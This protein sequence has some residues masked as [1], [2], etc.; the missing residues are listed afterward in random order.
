[1]NLV[2]PSQP[3]PG[4]MLLRLNRPEA[5]N[6]LSTALLAEL[7]GA[8]SNAIDDVR[9]RCIVLTGSDQ[10]FSCGADVKEMAARGIAVL[11]DQT[12]C[13]DWAIVEHCPKPVIAAVNGLALGGG[14]ELAMLADFIIASETARFGQPEINL[15]IIPGDGAT[16]RLTRLVGRGLAA[17]MILSGQPIDAWSALRAGLVTEVVA[18]ELLLG[19]SLDIAELIAGKAALAARFAKQAVHMAD[20]STLSAGLAI[21]RKLLASAFETED[22]K[23]GMAA[24]VQ[25]RPARFTGR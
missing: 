16:Q 15:G 25:K 11:E 3:R 4:V 24:F 19:T 13:D 1:M 12:R 7:A 14:C 8:F 18:P 5:R 9:M 17:R 21:E 2:L 20:E 22:Q 23:E 10:L 6:A